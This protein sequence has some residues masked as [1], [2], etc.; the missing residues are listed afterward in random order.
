VALETEGSDAL[1]QDEYRVWLLARFVQPKI[2]TL[3]QHRATERPGHE[4]TEQPNQT[5]VSDQLFEGPQ[6]LEVQAV[7][8]LYTQSWAHW[9]DELL[10]RRHGNA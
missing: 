9:P 3:M 6:H 2:A 4:T 1:A 10:Q 8:L 7:D 5:V